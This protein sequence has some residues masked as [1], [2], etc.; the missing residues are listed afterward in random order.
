[1]KRRI[2]CAAAAV[3]LLSGCSWMEGNYVSVQP[4]QQQSSGTQTDTIYAQNYQQLR[5]VMEDLVKSGIESA[6]INVA[7]YPQDQVESAMASAADYICDIMPLGAYAVEKIDY[8]IGIGGGHPAVSVDISYIHGRSEIRQ[9]RTVRDMEVAE[10]VIA[11]N[12]EKCNEGIVLLVTEYTSEDLVQMVE[13]YAD[14]NPDSVMETP[15]V[16]VGIYPD[17]G[18]SRVVELKFSYQTSRDALRQMQTQVARVFG[19]AALYTNADATDT[20]KCS[21]LYTFL[22]ERSDYKIKT[23]ITP[24]YSLLVHG[25]GDSEAFASV[26]AAM[27]RQ[28]GLECQTVSG[29]RAG[30]PWYWNLIRLG[31][32]YFH[33]DLL[34]C[35]ER[36]SFQL[37]TDQEMDGYVWDYSAYTP[38]ETVPPNTENLGE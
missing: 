10:R 33:V 27:C 18:S 37:W 9:I 32:Q 12:L 36:G 14:Q 5:S 23:S 35:S 3:L 20:Q 28:A 22:M 2:I 19:S 7:E 17:V 15:Q 6:V 30:E 21:Q 38:S 24:S 26:Y 8:E 31:D 13:D 29:T 25:V 4:H 34:R 1:M 11:D 16:A